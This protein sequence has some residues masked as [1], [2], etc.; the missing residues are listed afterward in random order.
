MY[1]IN[2]NSL[3]NICGHIVDKTEAIQIHEVVPY[4][5]LK[6][7]DYYTSYM[8]MTLT[9]LKTLHFFVLFLLCSISF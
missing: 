1:T 6:S 2:S 4:F 5:C 9:P 7:L 8:E 3:K